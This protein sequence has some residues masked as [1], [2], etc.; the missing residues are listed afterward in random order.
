M[1]I[2]FASSN[3]FWQEM[4]H[5]NNNN[6]L[7]KGKKMTSLAEKKNKGKAPA[8]GYPQD[9]R[10]SASQSF[11]MHEGVSSKGNLGGSKSL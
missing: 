5:I 10:L 8:Q 3:T 1:K 9:K 2:Y 11:V 4:E 7:S 6:T